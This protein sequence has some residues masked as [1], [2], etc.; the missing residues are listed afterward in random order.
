MAA[1]AKLAETQLECDKRTEDI[2]DQMPV[3]DA[4]RD[5][6][7]VKPLK[8]I[9]FE[10]LKGVVRAPLMSARGDIVRADKWLAEKRD[11]TMRAASNA[12]VAAIRARDCA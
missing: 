8:L 5:K 2:E 4:E 7:M 11:E 6:D 9:Y 1:R 3:W 10:T 12:A